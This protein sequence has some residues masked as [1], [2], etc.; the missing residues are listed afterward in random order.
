MEEVD[1]WQL[2]DLGII[3]DRW[4]MV[5]LSLILRVIGNSNGY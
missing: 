1:R 2:S 5:V 4:P 3:D